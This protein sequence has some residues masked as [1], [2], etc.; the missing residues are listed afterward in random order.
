MKTKTDQVVT[1]LLNALGAIRLATADPYVQGIV[2]QAI[3][4]V[5]AQMTRNSDGY[6]VVKQ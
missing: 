3:K 6:L 4:N 1:D 5:H 2:E